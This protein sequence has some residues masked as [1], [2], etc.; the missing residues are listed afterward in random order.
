[1]SLLLGAEWTLEF[2]DPSHPRGSNVKHRTTQCANMSF[3]VTNA[4]ASV[5]QTHHFILTEYKG[6]VKPPSPI[7][8]QPGGPT[9]IVHIVS[10]SLDT[11]GKRSHHRPSSA[12]LKGQ[13]CLMKL[14]TSTL[15]SVKVSHR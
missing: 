3:I 14:Q 11:K 7:L 5:I 13:Q 12:N 2:P 10:S 9:F 1:M 8:C 4:L 6:K 15:K